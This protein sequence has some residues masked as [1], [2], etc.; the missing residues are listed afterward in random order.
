V[1]MEWHGIKTSIARHLVHHCTQRDIKC[2]LTNL[3]SLC[4]H[5][6]HPTRTDVG[7]AHSIALGVRFLSLLNRIWRVVMDI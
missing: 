7:Q 2:W 1:K 3:F 4:Y 6:F 5:V